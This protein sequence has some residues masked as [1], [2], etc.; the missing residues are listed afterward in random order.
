M[1]W[2]PNLL[3]T[4]NLQCRE[5]VKALK[6]MAQNPRRKTSG[7]RINHL[8]IEPQNTTGSLFKANGGLVVPF[9]S[10]SDFKLDY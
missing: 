1:I 8:K 6:N 5:A 10:R 7:A 3:Q 2:Q 9:E 4:E